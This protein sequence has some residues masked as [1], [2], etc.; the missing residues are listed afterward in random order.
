MLLRSIGALIIVLVFTIGLSAQTPQPG[1]TPTEKSKY[2]LLVE[3]AK[4]KDPSVNFTELRFAFYE[5][6]HWKKP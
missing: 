6:P 2:D 5:S 3:K 4:Q 1:P